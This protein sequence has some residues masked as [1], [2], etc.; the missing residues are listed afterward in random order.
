MSSLKYYQDQILKYNTAAV[1]ELRMQ[2]Y[3]KSLSFLKQALNLMKKITEEPSKSK[4]ICITF[5]N[6][7]SFFKKL[8]NF[9]EALK[10]LNKIVELEE[11]IPE[12]DLGNVAYAHLSICTILSQQSNH[13]QA[14]RHGLKSIYILKGLYKYKPKL[15][16]SLVIAYQNV[17]TEYKYIGDG[18]NAENSYRIGY[19]ISNELLGPNSSLTITLKNS[20]DLASTSKNMRKTQQEKFRNVVTP[21][22]HLPAVPNHRANSDSRNQS[23]RCYPMKIRRKSIDNKNFGLNSSFFDSKDTTKNNFRFKPNYAQK[24]GSDE[25]TSTIYD[26]SKTNTNWKKRI[27]LNVHKETEKVA[28][29]IIQSWWRGVTTRISVKKLKLVKNL[30]KA[31]QKAKKAMERY[32]MLKQQAD[33]ISLRPLKKGKK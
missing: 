15:V 29:T 21:I 32:E 11:K 26:L 31:E 30:K 22:G 16:P 7:G 6:L 5:N 2:N 10:Y 27:N 9:P 25:E 4:L 23:N 12:R 20:W 13:V 1:E 8:K 17:G 3:D 24:I 14:L 28:A 19:Q 33:K 18:T